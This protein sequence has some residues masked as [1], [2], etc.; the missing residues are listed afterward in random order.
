MRILYISH[1]YY[2]ERA[3]PVSRAME[4]NRIWQKLGHEP[5]VLTGFPHFP[6]GEIEPS[7]RGYSTQ[8]ETIDG[9]EVHRT[10]VLAAANKGIIKRSISFLSFAISA[11]L[12]ATFRNLRTD[13]VVATSPQLFTGL[14]G[15]WLSRL[16]RVPFI[17]EVRDLWPDSIAA[18]GVVR[19]SILIRL[20][21]RVEMFLYRKADHIVTVTDHLR[22]EIIK[23]GMPAEKI[24]VLSNGAN[25]KLFKPMDPPRKLIEKLGI[26]GKF[27]VAYIG[28]FANAYDFDLVLKVAKNFEQKNDVVFFLA[29][30]GVQYENLQSY[31]QQEDP[32]MSFYIHQLPAV[33]CQTIWHWR[34][35]RWCH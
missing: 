26:E 33:N 6:T 3:A 22:S 13:V 4:L 28:N 23:K 11:I 35:L 31:L 19:E 17:F 30:S 32:K 27:V 34:R 10:W 5:V 29:G 8:R 18:L 14:V 2:P 21:R 25:T 7:Y 15:Y 24:S 9:V 1:Y 16:R 12:Y 20:L